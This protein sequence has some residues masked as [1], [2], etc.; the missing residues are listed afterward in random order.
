MAYPR[1]VRFG[2]GGRL[3]VSDGERNSVFAFAD[4]G[5][6]L[7]EITWD[8]VAVPYLAG[9]RGDTL[10]VFNPEDR[11]LDFVLN[12][13]AIRN[14]PTPTDLPEGPLH[15]AAATD[16]A[17]YYKVVGEDFEGYLALLDERGGITERIPL[18]GPA[19]RYAGL[20]RPW[21]D[22]ILS[23]TG[24]LPAV[25]VLTPDGQLDSLALV[26]FD[27]PMLA[28]RFSFL[29]GDTHEAPLLSSSAAPAGDWLFVLNLRPGWL[30]IDVYDRAGHLQYVLTQPNPGY[31][32]QFYPTDLDVRQDST[33]A[34]DI[35]VTTVNPTQ[36]LHRYRWLVP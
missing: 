17:L 7:E 12:G 31:N 19:W 25:D 3:F 11:R 32:K 13:I 6:W 8:S 1:T 16:S 14:L 10:I 2:P 35:A 29:H 5:T 23:L 18:P 30:R 15:Y 4:D 21:G 28:R 36:A 33:G 22:S 24:F 9:L 26:G 27:S 34:F 20:I